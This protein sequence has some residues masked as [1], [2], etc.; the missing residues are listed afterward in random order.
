MKN[1][2]RP[3]AL[4][5]RLT[6]I[7]RFLVAGICL[8]ATLGLLISAESDGRKMQ[9]LILGNE[10]ETHAMENTVAEWV[11]SIAKEG[12]N[13]FYSISPADLNAQ[14]L[15]K[16]DVL[17]L[18]ANYDTLTPA[19]ETAVNDFVNNGKGLMAIHHA[20]ES[21]PRSTVYA[22][23]IGGRLD[24]K[25]TATF[26]A[27]ILQAQHPVTLGVTAFEAADETYV[28]KELS[29]D[30]TVLMERAEGAAK[31]PV[32]WVRTQGRGRVFYTAYGHDA[33]TWKKEDFQTLLHNALL[34]TAG[35]AVRAEWEKLEVP[36][37]IRRSSSYVPNYERRNPPPKYQVPLSPAD[38]MKLAQLPAG[39]ELKLFA[40]EPDVIKPI[41]MNWDER[42][43]LWVLE[44][45]DYPNEIHPGVPGRDRIKILEDTDGDG[46]A[47][48]FT[49]FAEG[50]NIPTGLCFY[51]GGV[52]VAQVPEMLYFKDTDG[53]GK[54][55]VRQVLNTGWG[56]R[57][58]HSGPSNLRWGYDNRI[59]GSVGYSGFQGQSGEATLNF[60][61]GVWRMKTDGTK[62][63][64]VAS[65]SNNTWG[66]GL[67]ETFDIFGSTANNTHSVYVGIPNKYSADVKGLPQRAGSRKI[68]GHYAFAPISSG[69]RQVDVHGGY[70]AAAGFNLYTAR[71]YPKEFWNRI[72]F[73]N[74]P[75]GRLVHM[76]I[77]DKNGA[78]YDEK[79]G[80]N[81]VSNSD[82]W[83][84]PVVSEVGPDGNVWISDF[85]NFVIQHNPTPSGFQNGKGNA[86]IN[87]L[88]DQTHGRI[89]RV[90][91]TGAPAQKSLSLSKDRPAEL[92]SALSNDNLGWRM[93]AQRLLVER[94]NRDVAGQLI[95]LVKNKTVD[96]M[97]MN[98]AALHALWTLSGLGMIDGSNT[99]ASAA[100]VEAMRHPAAAVRKAAVQVLPANAATLKEVQAAGLLNDRDAYTR[101]AALLLL[102]D[103]TP[104]DEIGALLYQASKQASVEKDEWLSQAVYDGAA[105]HRAGFFK[106]YTAD[107]GAAPFRT[108]ADRIAK[109]EQTPQSAVV[110]AGGGNQRMVGQSMAP[111]GEKLL[112]AYVEDI[113]G[114]I[115]RP[116]PPTAGFRG[117]GGNARGGANF[118]QVGAPAGGRGG[119]APAGPPTIIEINTVPEDMTYSVKTFTVKPGAYVR[120]ILTNKDEMPHNLV[121]VRPGSVEEVGELVNIMAKATDAAERSY[122]PPS[123]DVLVWTNM[124]EAGQ[125]GTLEFIAP[126]TAGDYPY[127]CTFPGHWKTMQGMMKVAP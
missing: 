58:T 99:A 5:L 109:E 33:K 126:T 9:V 39:F 38:S 14:K 66:L 32:T 84:A 65:F 12:V 61:Q 70:T 116:P 7:Q 44:S 122:I 86:Y 119:A 69:V 47:D 63:E 76:A 125:K 3:A 93:H 106:A 25:G 59:W 78:G 35:D 60:L 8:L 62:L 2:S 11:P 37:V 50:L 51:N 85:Y 21:F 29:G 98:P 30:R 97:G 68:D 120:I 102:A 79:D 27:N 31:E 100:A 95:A 123:Q 28:H 22:K 40:S 115:T 49:V 111:V 55:D 16:F 1:F 42:G 90:V 20:A 19:Q 56:I 114:P 77:L 104:S 23:L 108:L 107:L 6:R 52:I 45:V 113:V 103:L 101:L 10:G 89:Y 34:W 91:Y 112:H 18:Y 71:V 118:G 92:V 48:K 17:V 67:S 88:R 110:P 83:F 105:R 13:V 24:R 117:G 36:S 46:K 96:D 64:L 15:S 73:V 121:Y 4:F 26:T 127:L 72:A 57:D 74:E 82:E 43:R 124:V 87:P 41:S 75:T 54:A 81:L 94:G 80:F 53:D